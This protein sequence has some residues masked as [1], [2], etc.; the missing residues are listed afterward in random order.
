MRGEKPLGAALHDV[1]PGPCLGDCAEA[2]TGRAGGTMLGPRL[3]EQGGYAGRRARISGRHDPQF[4]PAFSVAPIFSQVWVPAL[5]ASRIALRDTPKQT[6]TIGPD[7]SG[8]DGARPASRAA[9]SSA[10]TASAVNK[11]ASQCCDASSGAAPS[12]PQAPIRPCT[13]HAVLYTPAAAS[14]NSIRSPAPSG[15]RKRSITSPTDSVDVP[16][17][18]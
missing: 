2:I 4:V 3:S 16:A 13:S 9:R 14:W 12:T 11:P 15:G 18:S 1:L 8:T 5:A 17:I 6:Q 7:S 10:V